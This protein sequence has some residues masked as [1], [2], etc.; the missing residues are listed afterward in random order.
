[1][2]VSI[3]ILLTSLIL[4]I[5]IQREVTV[6]DPENVEVRASDRVWLESIWKDVVLTKIQP[7]TGLMNTITLLAT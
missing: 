3:L 6:P 4:S 1:M 5:E 2:G 7:R